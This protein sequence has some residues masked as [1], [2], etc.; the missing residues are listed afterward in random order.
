MTEPLTLSLSDAARLAG[1]APDTLR[2]AVER[3][4]LF[5]LRVGRGSVRA[6]LRIRKLLR[7][8]RA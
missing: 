6:H 5:A 7:C 8:L 2:A 3:G 1:V 4:E